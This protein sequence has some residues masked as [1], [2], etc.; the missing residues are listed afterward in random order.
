MALGLTCQGLNGEGGHVSCQANCLFAAVCVYYPLM[1]LTDDDTILL[2]TSE[3]WVRPVYEELL[4]A[5]SRFNLSQAAE[6][7]RPTCNLVKIASLS[8]KLF[9]TRNQHDQHTT[10]TEWPGADCPV[11]CLSVWFPAHWAPLVFKELQDRD[12][13]RQA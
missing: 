1:T 12:L 7:K 4:H 5:A 9:E 13:H 2:L 6:Y 10:M 3:F 11:D 8:K